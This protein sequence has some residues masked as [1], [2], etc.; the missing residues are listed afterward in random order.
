M[1]GAEEV[2]IKL[3]ADL[4]VEAQ[5]G[6]TA[7]RVLAVVERGPG[8]MGKPK[9]W[10]IGDTGERVGVLGREAVEVMPPPPDQAVV[11]LEVQNGSVELD[12]TIEDIFGQPQG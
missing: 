2:W 9:W 6:M 7:G 4:P 1:S 5:H 8:G 10:V 12:F 3:K 11:T